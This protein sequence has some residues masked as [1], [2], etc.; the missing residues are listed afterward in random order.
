[1]TTGRRLHMQDKD[2]NLQLTTTEVLLHMQDKDNNL[3]LTTIGRR[4][5]MQDKGEHQ[6]SV[7][8]ALVLG[9]DHLLLRR[10]K[11]PYKP[12]SIL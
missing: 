3:Q 9:L 5:H 10:H 4:L 2:N 8:M 1:M 7:G 12:D 11:Y 6:L